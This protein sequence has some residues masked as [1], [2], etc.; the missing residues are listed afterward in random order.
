MDVV[1]EK[2]STLGGFVDMET[3]RGKGSVFI[4]T[5]PITLAILKA[6]IVRVGSERFA[7]PLTSMSES[8]LIGH[9]DVQTIEG[10]EVYNLRGEML[11]MVNIAKM[12]GLEGDVSDRSYAVVV[13]YGE[14]RLGLFVDEL[15]G[16][17]E[18]V[19][20]S[21]GEYFS[22]QRGFAGAGEIG[23][24]EVILVIDVESIIEES[25]FRQRTTYHV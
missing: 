1:K 10:K 19:I 9:E 21:L 16:Q 25:L 2:L 24:H 12:F 4:L 5:V 13:G 22:G 8:L 18:V 23:R 15:I 14:R 11:P 20:K 17:H 7:I 6:L 3:E